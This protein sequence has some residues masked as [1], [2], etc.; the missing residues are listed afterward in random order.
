MIIDI[1][2]NVLKKYGFPEEYLTNHYPVD[3]FDFYIDI[4]ARGI[5]SAWHVNH[6]G[7]RNPNTT[8][9]AYE[10][11]VPYIEELKSTCKD[12]PNCFCS[13]LG[14][15]SDKIKIPNGECDCTSL[16]SIFDEHKFNV[17]DNWSIKFD[18]EGCEYSL[19]NNPTDMEIIKNASHIALEFHSNEHPTGNFFTSVNELPQTFDGNDVW[20][21]SEFSDTHKIFLTSKEPGLRT[22][23]LISNHIFSD[24][25]NLFW[26]DLI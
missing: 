24:K 18:C 17:N 2:E 5:I 4:G 11:D 26:K 6:I 10:P 12:L 15:G 16:S 9:V 20:L 22:Y 23:V 13:G 14:Y 7:A 1:S 21:E 19:K 8:C 25:E 3:Y